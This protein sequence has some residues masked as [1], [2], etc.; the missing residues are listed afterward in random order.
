MRHMV[1]Q[2]VTH[3]C[4]GQRTKRRDDALV[5]ARLRAG[6]TVA[7][8]AYMFDASCRDVRR[9]AKRAGVTP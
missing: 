2:V 1:A 7:E 3:G 8:C 6:Y 5:L 9:I 4:Q